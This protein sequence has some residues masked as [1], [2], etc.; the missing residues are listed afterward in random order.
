MNEEVFDD[1]DIEYKLTPKACALLDNL[2]CYCGH[3]GDGHETST[4]GWPCLDPK[5]SCVDYNPNSIIYRYLYFGTY[6]I[7]Q[8]DGIIKSYIPLY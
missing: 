4:N 1:S 8:L 3:N 5:C 7:T 6:G 2:S